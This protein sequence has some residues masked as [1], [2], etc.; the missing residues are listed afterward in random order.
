[1]GVDDI[2]A[3]LKRQAAAIDA[4]AGTLP[5]R[6]DRFPPL[7]FSLPLLLPPI[8]RASSPDLPPPVPSRLQDRASRPRLPILPR[9]PPPPPPLVPPPCSSTSTFVPPPRSPRPTPLPRPRSTPTSPTFWPKRKPTLLL[10]PHNSTSSSNNN[11][12][13]GS[14]LHLIRLSPATPAPT[15]APTPS[16]GKTPPPLH[17]RGGL[18]SGPGATHKRAPGPLHKYPKVVPLRHHPPSSPAPHGG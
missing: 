5:S 1:M 4:R 8:S 10:L 17:E 13:R 2:W 11:N 15:P 9:P 7:S 14:T 3:S 16:S 12:D 6:P 18:G